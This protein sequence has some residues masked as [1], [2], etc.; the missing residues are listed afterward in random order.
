MNRTPVAVYS[1]NPRQR[2]VTLTGI[3]DYAVDLD[4]LGSITDLTT[5]TVLY[6]PSDAGNVSVSG[7]TVTLPYG[8]ISPSCAGTDQLRI[9]YGT[10]PI[11]G[12]TANTLVDTLGYTPESTARKGQANGYAGLDSGG[13]VPLTYLPSSLMEYQG[14][15]NASTNTPALADGVGNTGDVWRV[16][17]GGIFN[18]NGSLGPY[19]GAYNNGADYSPGQVVLY[20]GSYYTRTGEP[21]PGY[22]PGTGYWGP[23]MPRVASF[24]VGDYAIYNGATWEKSDTT[25]AVATVNGYTGNVTL[26]KSDVGLSNVDNTS[27]A[28]KPV[29]TA[30]TT[31]LNGKEPTITAGTT[32]QYY[33]GDKTWQALTKS[34]AGLSNVDNTSNATE[35]AATASLTNKNLTSGTNT[36]PTFNQNTTGSAAKL[37]TAR[38]INGVSFDGS[39]DITVITDNADGTATC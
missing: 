39:A 27:D 34:D 29:S 21:N 13:K 26:T 33:R 36:F 32:G 18:F 38:A 6:L 25:D 10:L 14:V 30:A 2:T 8:A 1:F 37:T 11:P 15:W 23:A 19:T 35:R 24:E 7:K 28:N 3:T 22:P 17:V 20:N 4:K 5:R 9:L 12:I 31:A 16:A